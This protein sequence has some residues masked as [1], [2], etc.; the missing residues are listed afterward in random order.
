MF[1]SIEDTVNEIIDSTA[2]VKKKK[3]LNIE[4]KKAVVGKS[5]TQPK[6]DETQHPDEM[7]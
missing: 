7:R 5:K 3:K 4:D 2:A 6:K 1:S